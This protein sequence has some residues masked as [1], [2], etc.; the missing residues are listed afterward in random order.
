[1]GAIGII[2]DAR[3]ETADPFANK[4]PEN[5]RAIVHL[6]LHEGVDSFNI[7]VPQSCDLWTQYNEIRGDIALGS[8][9]LL[10]INADSAKQPCA[11]FGIHDKLT[12]VKTMYED[13]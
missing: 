13:G 6:F 12:F 11:T 2:G 1:M 7:L 4:E 3:N 8:H 9:D 5:Y 10:V